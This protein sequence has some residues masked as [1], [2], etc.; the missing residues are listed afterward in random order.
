MGLLFV[1]GKLLHFR[2]KDST[3]SKHVIG[4]FTHEAEEGYNIEA[5]AAYGSV[6]GPHLPSKV[7]ILSEENLQARSSRNFKE[8]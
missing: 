1:T 6:W 8:V 4:F 5:M 7:I 3:S 2:L